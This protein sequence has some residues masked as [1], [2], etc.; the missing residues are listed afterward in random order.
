MWTLQFW[1][2]WPRG[3]RIF[4]LVF[5]AVFIATIAGMWISFF[6]EPA[7]AITLRTVREAQLDEIAVDRFVKGPFDFTVT[8]N[9]YVILQRELGSVLQTAPEVGHVYVVMLAIFVIGM[10]AVISTLG[11]FYY[12]VG[13]GIF[14]LF[15]TSLSPE[16]L[17]VFGSYGKTFT[18]MILA[19]YG[20]PSFWLFY[21]SPTTSFSRR[22]LV[23][24]AVTVLIALIIN[25]FS[26]SDLPFLHVATYAA[27]GGLVACGLFIVTVAHEIIAGF[28]FV[29]T[30]NTK[31]G[32]SLNHFLIISVIYLVN[33]ALAY[34]V[35]FGFIQW[36]LITIDLYLLLTI[37]G[38]LGVWGIRQREKTY[39]GIVDANPHAVFAFLLVGAF[40]FATIAMFMLNANDT[41]LS[42]IT[43]I[44]IFAHVGFG[45]I[46]L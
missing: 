5:S 33:L 36:N 18:V 9:N 26:T 35:R 37:S 46:F 25:F 11:R 20:L 38:I 3:N 39:E 34:S 14:I 12:L 16:V 27:Q 17:G 29:V 30:Q 13:M 4:F 10:L 44:I 31:S 6:F 15:V 22:I 2:N 28:V 40:V 32:K 1:Q 43:D 8:G 42:A 23:F 21:F 7:P 41:A 45:L 19:L 24:A